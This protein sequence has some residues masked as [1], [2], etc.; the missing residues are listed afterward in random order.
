MRVHACVCAHMCAPVHTRLCEHGHARCARAGMRVAYA[1]VCAPVCARV[2]VRAR[3][4]VCAPARAGARRE[5]TPWP[6]KISE[7]SENF[8]AEKILSFPSL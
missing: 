1:R 7:T 4:R 2:C 3:P 6:S 8:E 5:L